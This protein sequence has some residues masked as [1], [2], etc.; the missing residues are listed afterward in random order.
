MSPG[1]CY[2]IHLILWQF[3]LIQAITDR[4]ISRVISD[5]KGN[6]KITELRTILQVFLLFIERNK[7][8]NRTMCSMSLFDLADM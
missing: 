2:Y 4:V 5:Y 8:E 3:D 6:N 1:M 7:H